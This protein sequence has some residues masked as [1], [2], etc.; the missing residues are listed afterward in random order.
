MSR[1]PRASKQMSGLVTILLVT[2]AA[3]PAIEAAWAQ[4]L[5]RS[6]GRPTQARTAADAQA[7]SLGAAIRRLGARTGG[8]LTVAAL[9]LELGH[10]ISVDGSMPVFMSSVVKLPL[11]I[12]LLARVDRGEL[13]LDDS[14]AIAPHAFAP[15]HSPLADSHP[16]GGTFAVRELIRRAV[17]ESDNTASDALLRYS[18]GPER[19]TAELR[20]LGVGGVRIDR[21]YTGYNADYVGA[22][23][24]P[25]GRSSRALFDTLG[26][27]VPQPRRD[28][29]AARFLTD[30]RDRSS[31]D[32]MVAL[33]AR[34]YR[35]TL[36][37][38]ESTALLL[39]FMTASR[40][41]A[42]RIVAGVPA[43]TPVAHKTG[44]WGA[45]RGVYAAINDV[46]IV[47]L[48]NGAGHLAIAIMV[49]GATRPAASVDSAMAQATRLVYGHWSGSRPR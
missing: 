36:L 33:L 13:R 39:R 21:Y 16:N 23:L 11:A 15:G 43:G 7:D 10:Q 41:P 24:P 29:A 14:I 19:A 17:S 42:T 35:G 6:P 38:S 9:H 5:S 28:S 46:G 45:W 27:T 18:G 3:E 34:L 22:E 44:T 2:L 8:T 48:P 30:S 40:N 1:R 32:A 26:R 25:R 12:Q 47:T 4:S 49:R 37:G 31:A 20:R